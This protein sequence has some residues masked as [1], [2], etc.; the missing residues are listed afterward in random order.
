MDRVSTDVI[1]KEVKIINEIKVS[2]RFSVSQD[3]IISLYDENLLYDNSSRVEKICSEAEKYYRKSI[4][5]LLLDEWEIIK[6]VIKFI[7]LLEKNIFDNPKPIELIY[8]LTSSIYTE[9]NIILDFFSG[10]A[11]TAHAV[12]NLNAEDGG[13]RKYIMVQLPEPTD[14]KV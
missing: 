14:E 7:E 13:N 10:S 3:N 11:T 4:T 9:E 8:N 1:I 2:S 12:M 6:K 5:D